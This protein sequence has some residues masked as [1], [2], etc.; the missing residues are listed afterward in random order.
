[1]N[2]ERSFGYDAVGCHHAVLNSMQSI[3]EAAEEPR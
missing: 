1:M 2:Y 3:Q